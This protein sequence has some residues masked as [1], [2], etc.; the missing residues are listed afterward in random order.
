M[1][2]VVKSN[3]SHLL[4]L[5]SVHFEHSASDTWHRVVLLSIRVWPYTGQHHAAIYQTP[6]ILQKH[7]PCTPLVPCCSYKQLLHAILSPCQ[8]PHA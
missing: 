7:T 2:A 4:L 6:Y 1:R 8:D 5:L 3:R